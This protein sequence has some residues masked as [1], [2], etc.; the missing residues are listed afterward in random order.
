MYGCMTVYFEV[1]DGTTWIDKT[2]KCVSFRR[3]ISMRSLETFEAVFLEPIPT[4]AR[5]RLR[6][7]SIV[8]FEGVVYES[9]KTH[10]GGDIARCRITAYTDLIQ[11]DRLVVYRVYNTGTKAGTIVKDLA[12]LENDVDLSNVD[13]D[14]T[15]ELLSP[16]EIENEVALKIM[17]AVARGTNYWLRMKPGKK[18]YF[19]PKSIGPYLSVINDSM[20]LSAEYSEDKWKLRNRVIYVG[21]NGEVLAD[22]SEGSGDMPLVVHDPF[23]TDRSEAL[24]RANIRLALNREYG[25]QLRVEMH[26][27]DFEAMNIDLG[28]TV[29][30]SLASLGLNNVDMH[31][32]EI[33]YDPEKLRYTLT[34][35]GKLEIF[36][37]FFEEAV[38]GDVAA[39]FGQAIKIPE[40]LS[41]ITITTE[42]IAQVLKYIGEVKY[43]VYVNKP[44]LTLY[45]SQ[46]IVLDS[47]G[48]AVLASGATQGSFEVSILP[49]SRKFTI[50]TKCEWITDKGDGSISAHILDVDD[51]VV[52]SVYD[53]CDS[54]FV[55]V[56]RWP[57]GFGSFT[58][59]NA[60]NYGTV[61][62][63]V[64]DIPFGL[65]NKYCLKLTTSTQG[66]DGEIYYPSTK[67]L[68][69][70]LSRFKYVRLYL[71]GDYISNFSIKVRLCQDN[72][73]YLEGNITIKAGKW[74]KYESF[75]ST[76]RKVGDPLTLN[77]ISIISPYSL[78][79]DSDYILLPFLR[80]VLRLKFT[81]RRDSPSMSSPRVKLVKIIWRE[82]DYQA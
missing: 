31:L 24:R 50:F 20:I 76:F 4:G 47:D 38:K 60:S 81:L 80:E 49:E 73:N 15:P 36:E 42:E 8:L 14:G 26:Q 68:N 23:L 43:P 35:G 12:S 41:T 17:Q 48:Y 30:V 9:S 32:M 72:N 64:S 61:N 52:E 11:Y 57:K 44:P 74:E 65:L 67:D 45:N 59:K 77:W 79:I 62:A 82:G 39:R 71:Y 69:I 29:R 7:D 3:S 58:C 78:L 19:K 70:L 37:E 56:S 46:N 10:R 21:A 2:S 75:I 55:Y 27:V 6:R 22:V 53:A 18:L 1:F 16:W 51:R 28:D 33:E 54:Q 13:E 34:L 40:M 5:V 63:S 25:R 66:Q